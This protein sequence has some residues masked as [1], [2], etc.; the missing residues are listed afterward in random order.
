[1]PEGPI[2]LTAFEAFGAWDV[3]ST[4]EVVAGAARR[5][6]RAGLSVRTRVLPVDLVE[7]PRVLEQALMGAAA[8]VCCG[9]SGQARAVHVERV[10]VNLADFRIPDASG[11]APCREPLMVGEPE[12]FLAAAPVHRIVEELRARSVPAEI[13]TSA[14][15]YVC[16]AVYFH[17]LRTTRAD[18]IPTVFLHLPP[19]PG[20]AA[21]AAE[22][23]PAGADPEA[24]MTL[25][26]Q[27]E[28]VVTVAA[29]LISGHPAP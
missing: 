18:G 22:R 8:V 2:L 20:A 4:I 23:D 15:T 26:L 12:A 3:N 27:V 7:A 6:R 19:L 16:N 24:G 5:L 25:D 28:A 21:I 13:S 17:A 14:G 1:M 9:L 29:S 10:A 11:R